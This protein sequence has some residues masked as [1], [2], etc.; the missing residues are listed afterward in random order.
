MF[1]LEV[2]ARSRGRRP[3][4][5]AGE[6]A[7][8]ADGVVSGRMFLKS[9]R[10]RKDSERKKNAEFR[11][12]RFHFLSF[13][14]QRFVHSLSPIELPPRPH[15]IDLSCLWENSTKKSERNCDGSLRLQLEH[16]TLGFAPRIV[17][18]LGEPRLG[19]ISRR[20]HLQGDERRRDRLR[21][22]IHLREARREGQG[23]I[24]REGEERDWQLMQSTS[25]ES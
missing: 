8:R 17:F 16:Q 13:R 4:W 5:R 24:E 25:F 21:C 20:L 23:T 10:A 11:K 14:L 2:T 7:E 12:K 15:D 18:P 3:G 9:G 19:G 6:G 1:R 22:A